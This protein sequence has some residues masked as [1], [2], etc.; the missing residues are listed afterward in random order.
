MDSDDKYFVERVNKKLAFYTDL[1][2][3]DENPLSIHDIRGFSRNRRTGDITLQFNS[4]ED[5]E[6]A[7]LIHATWVPALNISLRLKLPSYPVIVHGIPTSFDPN[8]S[9]DVGNLVSI[10][11]GILDSLESIKWANRHSIEAGK[12]FS[13]LIIHLRN[14]DEANKAIKNRL[15]FFS[16]LK[17]VEKSVRKLGQC[18]K[19]LE[20]GHSA[21]RCTA[22]Q[23]CSSCGDNHKD[24]ASCPSSQSPSCINCLSDIVKA[25]QLTNTSFSAANLTPAQ[26]NLIA[27]PATASSCPTRRRLAAQTS[28]KEFFVVNKQ[29][30]TS[31]AVR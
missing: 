4:Q 18:F 1:H 11:E 12:P 24:D 2:S 3:S 14:P 29:N 13:S 6:T 28:A 9:E 25:A 10:N 23:R 27:H 22:E 8:N 5:V 16:V 7:T 17:M 15:N 30:R 19:C 20:Y 31:H 26:L 21:M